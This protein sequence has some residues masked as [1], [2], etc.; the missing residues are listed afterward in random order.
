M[1]QAEVAKLMSQLKIAV[2]PRHR[3]LK[4][5][6]GPE[7]RLD[8]LRKTVTALVKHERIELNYQR[9]DEARG[10]AER[11]ISDAIRY[12]DRHQPTME[13]ADFWLTEKQLVHKLFKV[14]APR[15]E[16]YKV[17]ATRMYKAPKEYPG[18]YRKRAVLELRGNP[19]PALVQNLHQNR[20][21]LHNVLLDEAR[22]DFRKEKYAEIA[23]QI[24]A[25]PAKET[26]ESEEKK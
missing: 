16:E 7:G 4:N 23:A 1:N 9:A 8:K 10:Y 15:F 17:S 14:L 20:N 18:W 6:D 26:S 21:L 5:I 12:G 2:R 3:N 25:E 11:L 22:K 24:G 13:M 19:Y